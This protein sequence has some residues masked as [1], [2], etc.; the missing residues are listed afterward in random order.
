MREARSAEET[1]QH[2]KRDPKQ[3]TRRSTDARP[4]C[5]EST[6][7]LIE[8][9]AVVSGLEGLDIRGGELGTD[10]NLREVRLRANSALDY[11]QRRHVAAVYPHAG[12][13]SLCPWRDAKA[14]AER[15]SGAL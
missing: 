14:C 9:P 15:L 7:Q 1:L 6:S 11:A 3:A 10:A 12:W 5:H 2:R 4:P 8:Q 13:A